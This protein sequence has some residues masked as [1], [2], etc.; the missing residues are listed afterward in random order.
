MAST[1]PSKTELRKFGVTVGLAFAVFGAISWWRGHETPPKVLWTLAT[2]L[3]V[4]GLLAPALLGPVNR[5]W[6]RMAHVLGQI[7][8]RIILGILYFLVITPVGLL[9]RLLKGDPMDRSLKEP[10][11]SAW[12]KREPQ[13]I[14]LARYER[15]F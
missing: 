8:T 6:M 14:E 3:V 10:K 5:V 9:L 1:G 4:P 11:S 2:L 13:P 7:N 12:V 15:Q